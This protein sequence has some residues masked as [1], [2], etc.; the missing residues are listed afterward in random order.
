MAIGF[1]K[2][3]FGFNCD[4]VINYVKKLYASF[5]E[6]EERFKKDLD[7]LQSEIDKLG[8]EQKALQEEKAQLAQKIAE[9]EAKSAEMERLSENIGKLY[10]VA[11]SNAKTIMSNAEENSRIAATEIDKNISAIDETHSALD[12]LRAHITETSESFNLEVEALMS[13][14][15]ATKEKIVSDT[16][17]DEKAKNEFAAMFEALTK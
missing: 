5:T 17:A 3:L 14:L 2:S 1:R 7:A 8:E 13:S 4:D 11:Q 10:L 12:A 16:T 9:Y 6:K 15:S